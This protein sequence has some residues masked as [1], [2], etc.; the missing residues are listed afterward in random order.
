MQPIL[1]DICEWPGA[2]ELFLGFFSIENK[3][4]KTLSCQVKPVQSEPVFTRN[5][6]GADGKLDCHRN[7]EMKSLIK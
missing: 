2:T 4:M 7:T 6:P 3:A 5:H 1:S